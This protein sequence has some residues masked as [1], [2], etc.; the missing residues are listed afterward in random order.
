MPSAATLARDGGTIVHPSRP[1][2]APNLTELLFPRPEC[3]CFLSTPPG[4]KADVPADCLS[5]SPEDD[6]GSLSSRRYF[7]DVR[8]TT[9]AA[10]VGAESNSTK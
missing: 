5:Y 7:G 3:S 6:R 2:C 9:S 10:S 1:V 4:P 8:L